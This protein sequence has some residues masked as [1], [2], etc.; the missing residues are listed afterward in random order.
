MRLFHMDRISFITYIAKVNLLDENITTVKE[1]TEAPF[2]TGM[3]GCKSKQG[4]LQAYSVLMF[5]KQTAE[6]NHFI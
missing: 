6:Q 5:C 4:K 1:N 2:A 3:M